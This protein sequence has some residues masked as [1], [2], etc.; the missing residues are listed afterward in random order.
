[1]EEINFIEAICRDAGELVMSKI[2]SRTLSTKGLKDFVTDADIECEALIVAAIKERFPE[3]GLLTEESSAL[4][5]QS[6]RLW[7]LDPIDGTTNYAHG[8]PMF[9]VSLA[10]TVNGEAAAAGVYAPFHHE[11]FLAARDR[12]TTLNREPI[13]V[14]NIS[15]IDDALLCTGFSLRTFDMNE[16]Y[17]RALFPKSRGVRHDGSAALNLAYVAAG[18]LDGYWEFGLKPWDYAAGELLVRESGGTTIFLPAAEPGANCIVA[19]NAS[20]ASSLSD[21]LLSLGAAFA[22]RPS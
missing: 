13:R 15:S 10:L 17:F 7:I 4:Q 22:S 1:M 9:C 11:M 8:Y 16:P 6:N 3:D 19:S 18:R 2:R 5:G 20:V 21:V 14:S 12:G